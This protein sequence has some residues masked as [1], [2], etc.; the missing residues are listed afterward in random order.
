MKINI[1]LFTCQ[2]HGEMLSSVKLEWLWVSKQT[3]RVYIG[4]GINVQEGTSQIQEVMS[5]VTRL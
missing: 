3:R 1:Q 4:F 5:Q 2:V